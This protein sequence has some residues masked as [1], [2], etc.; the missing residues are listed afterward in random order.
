MSV[1]NVL[2]VPKK[3]AIPSSLKFWTCEDS[4]LG[5][6]DTVPRTEVVRVFFHAGGPFFDRDSGQTG[7]E[8][9]GDPKVV[10][11]GCTCPLS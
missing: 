2:G 6:R 3:L 4:S 7:E 1:F 9:L 8:D 11:C 10:R 5:S